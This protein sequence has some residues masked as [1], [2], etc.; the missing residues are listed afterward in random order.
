MSDERFEIQQG[1]EVALE[2][3]MNVY[4]ELV[5]KS[6]QLAAAMQL[7]EDW[8]LRH[9]MPFNADGRRSMKGRTYFFTDLVE[10]RVDDIMERRKKVL[11]EKAKKDLIK[12]F[13]LSKEQIELL[14]LN[15]DE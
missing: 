14:G 3:C 2:E 1:I 6:D 15:D 7:S 13:G 12:S 11:R 4:L 5:E 10:K 8:V 9:V